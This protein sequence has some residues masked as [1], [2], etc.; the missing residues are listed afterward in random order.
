M[1][2]YEQKQEKCSIWRF[3]N[4]NFILKILRI[5]KLRA[6]ISFWLTNLQQPNQPPGFSATK[7]RG[8]APKTPKRRPTW[9]EEREPCWA[10]CR[11]FRGGEHSEQENTRGLKNEAR[12]LGRHNNICRNELGELASPANGGRGGWWAC[13]PSDENSALHSTIFRTRITE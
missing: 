10:E 2:N 6:W 12:E 3:D 8:S 7:V 1:S 5:W 4:I 13:E 11:G 9:F